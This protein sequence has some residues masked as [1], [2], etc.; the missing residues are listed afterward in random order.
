MPRFA[1]YNLEIKK[2]EYDSPSQ[3]N[4][5]GLFAHDLM[6]STTRLEKPHLVVV[7]GEDLEHVAVDDLGALASTM[8]ER[9]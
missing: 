7:P 9:G 4:W 5:Y 3:F 8:E 2:G 6:R 1:V